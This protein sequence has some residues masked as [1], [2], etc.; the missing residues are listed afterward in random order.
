MENTVRR[1]CAT[2]WDDQILIEDREFPLGSFSVMMEEERDENYTFMKIICPIDHHRQFLEKLEVGYIDN[3]LI[4]TCKTNILMTLDGLRGLSPYRWFDIDAER[5]F[6]QNLLTKETVKTINEHFIRKGKFSFFSDA[7]K[8][9]HT[10]W[11]CYRDSQYIEEQKLLNTLI[12]TLEFYI[13]LAQ[14]CVD[15]SKMI[16]DFLYDS[17]WMD[18]FDESSMLQTA[19]S[20]VRKPEFDVHTVYD[21]FEDEDTGEWMTA[22]QMYFSDFCGLITTD[23]FEGIMHNHHPAKCRVCK[24]YFLV[25]GAR[26]QVYC[27]GYAP[28]DMTDGK[29]ITCRKYAAMKGSGL[30]KERAED[31]PVKDCYVKRC[32]AI[33]VYKS[34]GKITEEFAKTASRIAKDRRDKAMR[35]PEYAAGDYFDDMS[36]ESIMESAAKQLSEK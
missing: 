1:F 19:L 16:D 23:F 12:E 26:R 22:R 5:A 7:E 14:S 8:H 25:Q 20:Q 36:H 32:S 11:L 29:Q 9:L 17:R 31:D 34:R 27:D 35:D 15:A 24:K 4:E 2:L 28:L 3:K 6:I 33:R 13:R 10:S 18:R 21:A 30:S